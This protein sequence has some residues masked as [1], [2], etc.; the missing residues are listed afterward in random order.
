[1]LVAQAIHEGGLDNYYQYRDQLGE[2]AV[3]KQQDFSGYDLPEVQNEFVSRSENGFRTARLSVQ[4]ISCA[5]CAWLIEHHLEKVDAVDSVR[6]NA[7]NRT[8]LLRW[9]EGKTPLSQ[10]LNEFQKIGY[11]PQPDRQENKQKLR[12]KESQQAL[13]RL[14]VAGIG[15]MQVGMVAVALYAGGMQGIE[16]HWQSFL[17][18]VSLVMATP[19]VFFSAQP[20]FSN[21]LR[22]L[23]ASHLNMDVPVSLAIAFAYAASVWATLTRTG[24]VY[25]D[26]V[27][28]FT[29]FLLLGRYLEMRARHSS[30]FASES[31]QHLLPLTACRME[32]GKL[33][34]IPLAAVL[35]GDRLWVEAGDVIPVDGQLM[36]ASARIDE[37]LLTGESVPQKK[38]EG[39][40]L[41]AGTL[42]G[43]SALELDVTRTGQSTQLAAIERLVDQASMVKP[44]QIALVDKI[45]GRFVGAV[46]LLA[47]IVGGVWWYIDSSKAFWVVLSVL[48]VTCPCALSLATPAA[49][50]AGINRARKM[51]LLISGP[52]TIESL[53]E[54]D[55][56]VFD[57]TGTLTEGRITVS[58]LLPLDS[59]NSQNEALI[60]IIAALEAHS[61][62]PIAL[63]FAGYRASVAAEQVDVVE[64]EGVSGCVGDAFYRFGRPAFASPSTPDLD[65]PEVEGMWQLLSLKKQGQFEPLL[66]VCLTDDIRPSAKV[67]VSEL[68]RLNKD[69]ALLSGDRPQPVASIAV[70]LGIESPVAE[71][72][73][74]GKLGWVRKQQANGKSVL[75]V[76]DGI[77]DV[78]VLSSADVSIAMG[79]ATR[80]AQSNADSVL[81][82]G[83]L[84]VIPLAISLSARVQRVIR[85]NLGWAL[86]YN[87]LALPAAAAGVLP[88]HLAA[89]G[90]SFSSLVVVLNAMRI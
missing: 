79:S 2:K 77:N 21:A 85:Q 82:S 67:A 1:M 6:V 22:S 33:L 7:T 76:G 56:V 70:Q 49:L 4:G 68:H 37:S 36:S 71:A 20:F 64:G 3:E 52:Q 18:W 58:Q 41:S 89:I 83:N 50:T 54:V 60:E 53:A 12:R 5:A 65:I 88:P 43:G 42:N 80:L 61:R 46:L 74:D 8:C 44:R 73:P 10:L 31:L 30:A 35:P 57:K 75:M 13:M 15:M 45:A 14:G 28:M 9:D 39:D 27:S 69:V 16:S 72:R 47:L 59:D 32:N 78:P 86:L 48:V 40:E 11:H 19:V 25:F 17:R 29:F 51:G 81:L 84:A 62:H 55:L 87:G 24:E 26:S 23:K 34:S 66:W 38:V 63:A 90:M